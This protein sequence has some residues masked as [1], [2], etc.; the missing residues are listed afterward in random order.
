MC[1]VKARNGKAPSERSREA[2]AA[3]RDAIVRYLTGESFDVEK[4]RDAVVELSRRA[5][6]EL[7]RLREACVESWP[8]ETEECRDN[9]DALGDYVALGDRAP[10]EMPDLHR[11]LQT[12][13]SCRQHHLTL[14]E[15]L[16][17]RERWLEVSRG[18]AA[19][20]RVNDES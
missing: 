16:A 20:E 5:P 18:L 17:E 12:C 6:G 2:V 19:R 15:I 9:R 4:L 7:E 11:H 10:A 1:A 14:A 8:A 3:A 13:R